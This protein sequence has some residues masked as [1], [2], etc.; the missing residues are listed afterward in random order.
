MSEESWSVEFS[1]A[2]LK[3][4]ERSSK[5]VSQ[6]I[7]D[8]LENLSCAENPL[9]HKDVRS[10]ECKLKAFYRLRVGEYRVIF[11]LDPENRRIGVVAVVPRGRAY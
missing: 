9:W 2:A 1:K 3:D 10:L 8:I 5:S 11:E 7:L 4:L 6:R